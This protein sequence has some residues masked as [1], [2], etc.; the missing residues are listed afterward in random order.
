MLPSSCDFPVEKFVDERADPFEVLFQREM[1]GV[2]QMKLNVFQIP[3]IKTCALDREDPIVLAP[4]NER[5]RLMRTKITLPGGVGLK[6][7]L[8]IVQNGELDFLITWA[9]LIGLIKIGRASCRERG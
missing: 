5:G 7:R 8:C 4:D 6:V 2:E 9:V 3:L 1:A